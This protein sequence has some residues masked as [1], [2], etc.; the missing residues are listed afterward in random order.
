[1]ENQ[2][3]IREVQARSLPPYAVGYLKKVEQEHQFVAVAYCFT[4]IQAEFII[5]SFNAQA[6]PE[7][8]EKWEKSEEAK[9]Q[10]K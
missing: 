1:M 4:S 2:W 10:E 3:I 5:D 6:T 8:W 9:A 7:D